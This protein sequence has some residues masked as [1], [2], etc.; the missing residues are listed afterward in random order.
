MENETPNVTRRGFLTAGAA[1]CAALAS[2]ARVEAAEPTAEENANVQ[3]VR[4]FCAAWPTK[5]LDKMTSYLAENVTIRWSERMAFING[6]ATAVERMKRIIDNA[7]KVELDLVDVYPKGPLVLNDR[8][9]RTTRQGKKTQHRLSSIFF[10]KEGKIVE[11]LDYDM[12]D[13]QTIR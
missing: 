3:I 10:I 4:D 12:P 5:N 7:E 11:W 13:P 1:A 8:W 2:N 6:K 9:D